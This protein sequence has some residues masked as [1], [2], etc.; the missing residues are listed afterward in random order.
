MNTYNISF[1]QLQQ[2]YILEMLTALE[3]ELTKYNIDFYLVG[4]DSA[5]DILYTLL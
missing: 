3:K 1:N 5:T 2:P 4:T